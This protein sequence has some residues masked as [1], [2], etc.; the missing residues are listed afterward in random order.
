MANFEELV[1]ELSQI[2]RRGNEIIVELRKQQTSGTFKE[3]SDNT[4]KNETSEDS[5]RTVKIEGLENKVSSTLRKLSV[6]AN[7][8]GYSYSRTAII[9]AITDPKLV[10]AVTKELYP[11]V[12]K[13]YGT[14]P[15][16]VERAIRHAI[17][18]AWVRGDAKDF[19]ELI[20]YSKDSRDVKP[21]NSEFIAVIAD[22]I[23][24]S[25]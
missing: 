22:R 15:S 4:T 10:H 9:M 24:L 14:T 5:K 12:A 8:K 11:K 18:V 2:V 19:E 16:R 21:T 23:L 3:S 1:K 25:E 7:I 17:E 20:G 13:Q 6:P